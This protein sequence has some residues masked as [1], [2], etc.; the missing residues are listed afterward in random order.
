MDRL[1]WRLAGI[2]GVDPG[3]LTLRELMLMADARSREAWGHT[4]SLL[5]LIANVNRDPKRSRPY[6]A[7]QFNPH[8]A[9]R[10]HRAPVSV[11][12]LTDEIVKV[13]EQ[14]MRGR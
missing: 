13:A 9:P 8:L 2:V 1:V 7:S 6:K 4:S 11:G 12:R 14:K 5:A 3:P 10:R